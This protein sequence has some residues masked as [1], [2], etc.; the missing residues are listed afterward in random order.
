[1]YAAGVSEMQPQTYILHTF[2]L[3]AILV[4][5]MIAYLFHAWG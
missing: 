1:V 5:A 2:V 4:A 3:F